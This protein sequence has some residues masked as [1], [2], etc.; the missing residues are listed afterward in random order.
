M[1]KYLA[2]LNITTT[3]PLFYQNVS[4]ELFETLI[5]QKCPI[6]NHGI[7]TE[8]IQHIKLD[9]ENA[10]QY[11]AGFVISAAKDKLK[12]PNDQEI[13]NNILNSMVQE[14]SSYKF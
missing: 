13:L 11:I 12:V 2:Q 14:V 4:Q 5:S 9:E 1:D 7:S 8:C 3:T 6:N 10:L